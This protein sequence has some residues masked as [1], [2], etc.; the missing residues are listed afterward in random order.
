MEH[1]TPRKQIF[2][3]YR[4]PQPLGSGQKVN[5]SPIL[6]YGHF[7]YQIEGNEAC[8]NT[9]VNILPKDTPLTQGVGSKVNFLSEGSHVAYQMNVNGA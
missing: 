7:A 6:E 8:S 5:Y 3:P 2:C 9:V 1:K 4:H